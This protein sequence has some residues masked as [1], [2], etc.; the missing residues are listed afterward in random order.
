MCY[1]S[2]ILIG[3]SSIGI[4]ESSYLGINV[5][6]IGDRQKGRERGKNIIDVNY[7]SLEI[8]KAAKK[9]LSKKNKRKINKLYGDGNAGKKILKIINKEKLTYLKM[10]KV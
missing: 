8:E 5:I 9:Y 6:N 1:N 3:N 7:N 4:R 10:L 2:R